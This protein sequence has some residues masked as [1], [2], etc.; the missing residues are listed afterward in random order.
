MV[1]KALPKQ[2]PHDPCLTDLLETLYEVGVFVSLRQAGKSV[3]VKPEKAAEVVN[4]GRKVSPDYPFCGPCW[5]E[6]MRAMAEIL[7]DDGG[8]ENAWKFSG[9]FCAEHNPSD[10][11]SRYRVDHRYRQLFQDEVTRQWALV[12]RKESPW[13]QVSDEAVVRKLAFWAVGVPE[14][15]RADTVR[16]MA[17]WEVRKAMAARFGVRG[18]EICRILRSV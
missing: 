9:R 13:E 5:R 4:H 2:Q 8:K 18:Q 15:T 11:M 16:E 3:G 17:E 12:K 7:E 14:R 10:P 1:H 6:M